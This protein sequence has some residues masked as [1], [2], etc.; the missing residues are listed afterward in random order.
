MVV[1]L[2]VVAIGPIS[3][4]FWTLPELHAILDLGRFRSKRAA[5]VAECWEA[6]HT[7]SNPF[8]PL[9]HHL[10]QGQ[11]WYCP[12][13]YR[14]RSLL[15]TRPLHN[16]WVKLISCVHQKKKNSCDR[17]KPQLAILKTGAI[18]ILTQKIIWFKHQLTK[19]KRLIYILFIHQCTLDNHIYRRELFGFHWIMVYFRS[20]VKFVG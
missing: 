5:S 2:L 15:S 19:T 13:E 1:A 12:K 14:F 10:I 20:L 6:P 16:R 3:G 4:L 18:W 11:I 17:Q 9:A 7:L 8:Y